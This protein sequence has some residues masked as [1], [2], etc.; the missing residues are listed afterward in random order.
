MVRGLVIALVLLGIRLQRRVDAA[1]P[2]PSPTTPEQAAK[3]SVER[4]FG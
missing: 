4:I 3:D 2:I 1:W